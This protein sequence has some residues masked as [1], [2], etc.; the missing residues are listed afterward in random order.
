[1]ATTSRETTA[2]WLDIATPTPR[3][4]FLSTEP[5][6]YCARCKKPFEIDDAEAARDKVHSVTW[7][8]S[9]NCALD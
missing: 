5:V 7:Y 2:R 8:C 4:V 6:R 3:L 9:M 1:M